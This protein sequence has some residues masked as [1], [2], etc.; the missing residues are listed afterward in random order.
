[1]L[2]YWGRQCFQPILPVRVLVDVRTCISYTT[3]TRDVVLGQLVHIPHWTSVLCL[4]L[5]TLVYVSNLYASA[6][7]AADSVYCLL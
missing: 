4:E 1:M 5:A 2:Q 6:I 3:L 7:S